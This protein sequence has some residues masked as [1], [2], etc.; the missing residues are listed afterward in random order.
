MAIRTDRMD[1]A[2]T[3]MGTTELIRTIAITQGLRT[4][5]TTGVEFTATTAIIITTIAT[6]LA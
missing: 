2:I 4:T 3:R 5:G 1:I 6:K